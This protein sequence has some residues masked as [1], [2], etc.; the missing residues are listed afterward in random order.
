MG[1][2]LEKA[3][4]HLWAD[5]TGPES[6]P[7]QPPKIDNFFFVSFNSQAFV[8]ASS[9]DASRTKELLPVLQQPLFMEPGTFG[10]MMQ[11]SI[12]GRGIVGNRGYS[13]DTGI[14]IRCLLVG[15]NP[16]NE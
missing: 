10:L 1:E 13:F 12:F 8:G 11:P 7:G 5:K 4:S 3:V 2:G 6:E 15:Q 14:A 16:T 9:V